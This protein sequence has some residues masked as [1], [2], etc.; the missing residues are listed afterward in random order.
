[1]KVSAVP[2]QFLRSQEYSAPVKNVL[3]SE[4]GFARK[5]REAEADKEPKKAEMQKYFPSLYQGKLSTTQVSQR[6]DIATEAARDPEKKRLYD[7]ALEFQSLFVKMMLKEMRSTLKP[8]NDLLYGGRTQE[9]FEDLLY[10]EYSKQMSKTGGFTLADDIYAQMEEHLDRGGATQKPV[11]P[12]T[13]STEQLRSE[14]EW[15]P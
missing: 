8:K 9:I 13:V 7:A 1:M 14:N 15:R 11:P 3:R 6:R 5:L 2:M 12:P 10:D 4:G